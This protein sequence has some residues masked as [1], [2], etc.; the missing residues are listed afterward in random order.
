MATTLALLAVSLFDLSEGIDILTQCGTWRAWAMA[1][2]ID[3]MFVAVEYSALK[4]G[5]DLITNAFVGVTLG[6]SGFLN[7]LAM[8]HGD[9][10]NRCAIGLGIF[11]PTAIALA[12]Y[13]L[14]KI[15]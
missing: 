4:Q 11:I 8:T 14:G 7:A 12:T 15:K 13:R 3:A 5:K 9:F 6:V 10:S 2:G 1:I